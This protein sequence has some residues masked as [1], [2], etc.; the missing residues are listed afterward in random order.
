MQ[1]ISLFIK[2]V[3]EPKSTQVLTVSGHSEILSTSYHIW[4]WT[5][6]DRRSL[7]DYYLNMDTMFTVEYRWEERDHREKTDN[8]QKH[9]PDDHTKVWLTGR[10]TGL[11]T[12]DT[13]KVT[14]KERARHE[15]QNRATLLSPCRMASG[16]ASF[17]VVS[18]PRSKGS[19]GLD[20]RRNSSAFGI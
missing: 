20:G 6:T 8:K 18:W 16:R 19:V 4:T 15:R 17:R 5:D 13:S 1:K 2:H 10:T 14:R 3:R 9:W 7:A 11:R 12:D